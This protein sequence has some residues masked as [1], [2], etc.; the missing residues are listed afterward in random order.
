MTEDY[1]LLAAVIAAHPKREVVGRTRLQK[2]MRLL[3]RLGLPTSFGYSIH[4]YGP[5]S[6]DLQSGITL[7]EVLGLAEEKQRRSNSGEVYYVERAS[8]EADP[9]LVKKFAPQIA[10][11]ADADPVVLELAATYDA[12]R[13]EG[14]SPKEALARLK[15]KKG[16]KCEGGNWAK[17]RKLLQAIGLRHFQ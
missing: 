6:E 16:K 10:I 11:M 13:E 15:R 4:F 9:K 5:Y 1:R 12:F 17:A 14:D 2:T 7:L 8:P 3:Q